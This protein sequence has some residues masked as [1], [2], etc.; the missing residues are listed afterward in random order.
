MAPFHEVAGLLDGA[1]EFQLPVRGTT[2]VVRQN[3]TDAWVVL[4]EGEIIGSFRRLRHDRAT[5]Y[6]GE[7]ASE[8]GVLDWASDELPTLVSRMLDRLA[9]AGPA[10]V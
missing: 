10:R 1:S 3:G 7:V 9:F 2:A 4:F 8:L 6:E 5:W